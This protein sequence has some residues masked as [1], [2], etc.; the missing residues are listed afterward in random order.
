MKKLSATLIAAAMIVSAQPA[1][2]QS[3]GS[4]SSGS[5]SSKPTQVITPTVT[6]PKQPPL[7]SAYVG[8]APIA[9]GIGALVTVI[10]AQLI[11][12]ATP[13]L[14]SA[15]DQ[16]ARTTGLSGVAGSSEGNRIFDF[17]KIDLKEIAKLLP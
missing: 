3:S 7:G 2:A 1:L 6:P 15:V 16:A 14:R 12:D 13:A 9:L 5:G 8:S 10:V 4:G 11:V 17:S